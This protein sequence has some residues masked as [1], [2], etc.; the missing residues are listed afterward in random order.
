M[1][2][3]KVTIAFDG[4]SLRDG[5]MN[6]RDLAPALLAFGDLVQAT[7]RVL[8]GER[9]EVTVNVQAD[10]KA[11]SFPVT[12]E[13]IQSGYDAVKQF[14]L[15]FKDA[16]DVLETIYQGGKGL[17]WLN[18]KI[19]ARKIQSA[20]TI[21]VDHVR[22][23][24]EGESEPVIVP[25]EVARVY[26]DAK[27]RQALR[28]TLRPL[29]HEGVEVFQIREGASIVEQVEKAE[30]PYFEVAAETMDVIVDGERDA[31]LQVLKPS[32]D[33]HLKWYFSDG[34]SA[35]HADMGDPDYF[36]KVQR[37]IEQFGSGDVLRVRLRSVTW[38]DG[39]GHLHTDHV[40]VKVIGKISPDEQIPLTS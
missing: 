14:V 12:L 16:K 17:I 20:T 25:A 22:L 27:A 36:S 28:S 4:R 30:M 26:N 35:F 34:T 7:N 15:Q 6:V 5:T 40:I 23:T 38:R 3:A 33:D 19:R 13:V 29:E 37:R 8:N 24:I 11:G 31:A 10:I 2:T 18:K 32:F 1:S 21:D 9:A 39:D